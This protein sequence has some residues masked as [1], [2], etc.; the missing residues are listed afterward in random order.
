MRRC[1]IVSHLYSTNIFTLIDRS[2]WSSVGGSSSLGFDLNA[3]ADDD[4]D[5]DGQM[6]MYPDGDEGHEVLKLDEADRRS[7]FVGN[8]CCMF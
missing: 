8:V 2:P 4:E 3:A 7:V 6:Q 1:E 5:V